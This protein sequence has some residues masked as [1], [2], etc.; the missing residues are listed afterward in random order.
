MK[1][2]IAITNQDGRLLEAE[3]KVNL[4]FEKRKELLEKW[5][6]IKYLSY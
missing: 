2:N 1:V 3:D 4:T 5:N 6:T